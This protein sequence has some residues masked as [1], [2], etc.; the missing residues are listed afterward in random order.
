VIEILQE[1]RLWD[2]PSLWRYY[3]DRE[4]NFSTIGNQQSRPEA[5][6]VEKVVNAVDA[7]L[8]NECWMRGIPPEDVRAPRTIYEAVALFFAGDASRCDTL[9]HIEHWTDRRRTEVSRL[10]T[11]AAT[12]ARPASEGS[13]NPCF[14]V[15]DAGEGQTPSSMPLTLLSLDK[16]NKARIRFVQG[17]FN[18]GGT[19]VLQFSGRHNLQFVVSRRN[20]AIPQ[21]APPAESDG[22]WGFT[23]VRR[24]DPPP[25]QKSSV[26]T[27]LAPVAADKKPG[28]G[29]VLCFQSESLP[30][31]PVGPNAYEREA[32]WGTA[33]KV[34]EYAATGF[35][36]M[37]FRKGGLLPRL[38]VLLPEIA[39]PIRLH[40]CREY[41]GEEARS[42]ETTLT[43][44]TV[45]LEDNK[46]DNLE[47]NFPTTFQFM[48]RGERMVAKTY[49]FRKEK[50]MTYRK[51]EGIVFT[52]NGQTHA[53]L[54]TSFFS[55][56]AVG[57]GRLDD[58]ILVIVDCTDLTGRARED[59]FMNSRD[60]LRNGDLRDAIE[61]ELEIVIRDH[62][63]LR[64]LRERRRRE[65]VESKLRDSKPLQEAL[66]LILKS[67]PSL[68]SLFLPGTR[69]SNPFKTKD[70][71]SGDL[72]YKGRPNP[73]YFK[74]YKVPYGER[75][76]RTAAINMRFRIV[77]ETDVVNDYFY[78]LENKGIFKLSSTKAGRAKE[79]SSYSLN[80]Q[81]GRA[82]L[83]VRL[84]ED[85]SVGD[86]IDY[87]AHVVDDTLPLPFVNRF[88]VTVAPPQQV[89]GGSDTRTKPPAP[90]NGHQRELPTGLAIPDI[91]EIYESDWDKR[92]HKFDHFSALEIVQEEAEDTETADNGHSAIYSFYVNM[93]N[94]Y[95]KTESKSSKEDL[96]ILKARWL[97]G[98]ALIGMAL[99]QADAKVNDS[100]E[101]KEKEEQPENAEAITLAERV[102]RI[103]AAV[104]PVLLPLVESLGSLSEE[105]FAIGSQAGDND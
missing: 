99:I 41:G 3:G 66:E 45:R 33:I 30:I 43:G 4:D 1:Q 6:L 29:G 25:G 36:T 77:F 58:S 38:D 53:H 9:G 94:I 2:D 27:Y 34:Y 67:S 105:Q 79:V 95:F 39:L 80:L 24:E 60:R 101:A 75:L 11:L 70:V 87:E 85:S 82:T 69:L 100:D 46:A 91:H 20:P 50:A 98:L 76:D 18:M 81:N 31:F 47:D 103:S 68:R 56:K 102:F 62:Q 19:G 59:L 12:G 23:V 35:R 88:M 7:V 52:V 89:R 51:N 13:R 5:A 84:P 26:Y 32:T 61:H 17:K 16:K 15:S 86:V 90:G 65:E 42:F 21:I 10:I 64:E 72:P 78:R 40:E 104:A 14:T 96:K 8:M 57:M 63:G 37:M 92:R 71:A 49:A 83:N 73:T 93:D 28:T 55:R 97:Y 22:M 44:L 74:L 48:A 54:P